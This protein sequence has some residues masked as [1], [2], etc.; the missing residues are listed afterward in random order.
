MEKKFDE[1]DDYYFGCDIGTDS[2]GWAVTTMDYKIKRFK[3]NAMWGVRL[4]NESNTAEGRRM[5]RTATRRLDRKVQRIAW[6]QM[7]FDREI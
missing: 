4:Y 6:L 5:Y 7:L 1:F 3:S 2:V